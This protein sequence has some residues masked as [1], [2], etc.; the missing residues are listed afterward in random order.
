MRFD[1]GY[2]ICQD[3]YYVNEIIKRKESISEVYFSWG[4]FPNGRNNQLDIS[5]MYP[6]EC[7]N[8]Q[9]EDLKKCLCRG[10]YLIF[11]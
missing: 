5:D 1:V 8:K 2:Q 10:F 11:Y 6:W 9:I 7:Q 3:D 4:D